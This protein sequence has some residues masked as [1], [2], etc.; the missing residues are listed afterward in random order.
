MTQLERTYRD[1]QDDVRDI[2]VTEDVTFTR[3]DLELIYNY[4]QPHVGKLPEG[5][6]HAYDV[7][8]KVIRLIQTSRE[9]WKADARRRVEERDKH[10]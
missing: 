2:R 1:E 9:A 10:D 3:D 5:N 8:K 6:D 4:L 7:F